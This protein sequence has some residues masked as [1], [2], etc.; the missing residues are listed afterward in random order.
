MYEMEGP[1][2]AMQPSVPIARLA[3]YPAAVRCRPD[4]L[5]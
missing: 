3:G 4:R 2:P 5:R 1:R